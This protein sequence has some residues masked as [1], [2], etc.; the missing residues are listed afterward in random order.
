MLRR[1]VTAGLGFAVVVVAG[2]GVVGLATEEETG[3][4]Q[5]VPGQH[6]PVEGTEVRYLQAGAGPDVLLV[7][8]S[9]GTVEDWE[10][11]FARL[12][13][14]YRVTAFDRLG[15]GYSGGA[16][17]PHTPAEN[18][19]LALGVIRALGL[20]DVVFVGHSYGGATALALALREP[21][22]VRA[23][24]VVGT[25]AYGPISVDPLF[26]VLAL[27]VLGKGVAAALAPLT[28][29]GRVEA[30]VRGAF[31]P[32]ADAIP[33]DFVAR[34]T[35]LWTR[36]TVAVTLSQERTTLSESLAAQSPRYPTIRKPLV[37]VCGEQD[38]NV[39]DSR[40]LA[41]EVPGARL[42]LLPNTGHYVQ[43][44]RPEVVVA[45]V[46]DAAGRTVPSG[47]P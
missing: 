18:A 27:P 42:V 17:R 28:G 13:A 12:A 36:P 44:A 25:R 7:H 16:K 4:P 34:R 11:V 19:T 26:R 40:R 9:P 1:L 22:E 21:P 14:H 43:Y 41:R 33:A 2:L 35:L 37:V 45:A 3:I 6:V 30:G 29:P 23:F 15:H 31:G 47:A 8:G 32:N 46:E 24:V 5:G 10:T 39:E 38:T 20:R